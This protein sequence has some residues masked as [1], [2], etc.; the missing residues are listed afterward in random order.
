MLML[1]TLPT[2]WLFYHANPK[3]VINISVAVKVTF[4]EY[5]DVSIAMSHARKRLHAVLF[6]PTVKVLYQPRSQGLSSS[7]L[8][9]SGG[10]VAENPGNED[11]L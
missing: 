9:R 3:T 4:P 8:S 5:F 11:G 1:A 10:R 2:G 6:L 7:S